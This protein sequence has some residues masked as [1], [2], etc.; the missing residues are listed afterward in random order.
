ML[1]TLERSLP[2]QVDRVPI[3]YG[4]RLTVAVAGCAFLGS[5]AQL[6]SIPAWP[7]CL[8][9]AISIAAAILTRRRIWLLLTVPFLFFLYAQA[10]TPAP[11]HNDLLRWADRNCIFEAVILEE[12]QATQASFKRYIA[13]PTKMLFPDRVTLTG[14]TVLNSTLVRPLSPGEHVQITG[15]VRRPVG[16][17]NPWDFDN[18]RSLARTG[19]FTLCT[20]RDLKLLP[21]TA[22]STVSTSFIDQIRSRMISFHIKTIGKT[23]GTL[24]SSIVLGDRTVQIAP[25]IKQEF[26]DVGLSHILAAS[27]FNL[28]LVVA[29]TY[30]LWQ[31]LTKRALIPTL[32]SLSA[33]I[34][35]VLLAG[36]S[37]SVVRAAIMITL[38]LGS[39]LILREAHTGAALS[40]ALL[41]ALIAD[42]GAASDVGLQLSY[43]ATAGIIGCGA[44]LTAQLQR[45]LNLKFTGWLTEAAAIAFI[46]QMSVLPLQLFY[47]WRIGLLFLP[48]NIVVSP[49]V[50]IATILGFASSVAAAISEPT[51]TL[52][53]IASFADWLA[54][55][56]IKALLFLTHWMASFDARVSTGPPS[57]WAVCL[58]FCAFAGFILS[59]R[60]ERKRF[61][62]STV[63]IIATALLL[64][65]PHA[66]SPILAC[67]PHCI[68]LV[69]SDRSAICHGNP[70][71]PLVKRFLDYHALRI[72]ST[73][74]IALPSENPGR[75]SLRDNS[76]VII[77]FSG[78]VPSDPARLQKII[79]AASTP[80]T[81]LIVV[82]GKSYRPLQPACFTVPRGRLM[83]TNGKSFVCDSPID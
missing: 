22:N 75:V 34:M 35:F 36:P 43:A 61:M 57:I 11:P 62:A 31:R 79:S 27:G 58:Y 25:A 20:A 67:F 48:A 83:F 49:L 21:P 42:P 55:L 39:K 13:Q 15:R 63:M 2:A 59:M 77:R 12:K 73:N 40:V 10:R 52:S 53:V 81:R 69:Y 32:M 19:T 74:T 23:E 72:R 56:P 66:A 38:A 60:L 50:P 4:P 65:R 70:Q 14:K 8:L 1:E 51:G 7:S 37:P 5:L 46:A 47:F 45:I 78:W 3:I 16:K 82:D 24:L 18:E 9:C 28:S 68:V 64:V 33:M 17:Q 41:C 80:Q 76:I 71:D 26:Q 30:W 54:A 6:S 29:V 44:T